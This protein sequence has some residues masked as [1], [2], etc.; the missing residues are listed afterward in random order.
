MIA[1]KSAEAKMTGN[2][3]DIEKKSINIIDDNSKKEFLILVHPW[4]TVREL[5]IAIEK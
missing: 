4:A 3:A 2:K 1:A 5:K